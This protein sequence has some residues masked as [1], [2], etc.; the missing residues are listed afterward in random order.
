MK[1]P[2]GRHEKEKIRDLER[3]ADF[4]AMFGKQEFF[5][6]YV[7]YYKLYNKFPHRHWFK[8]INKQKLLGLLSE[9]FNLQDAA[10]FE[11]HIHSGKD[12]RSP[13]VSAYILG[14]ELLLCFPPWEFGN[15]N[16]VQVYY[17]DEVPEKKVDSIIQ[18]IKQC[19]SLK[20][21]EKSEVLL[22]MQNKDKNLEFYEMTM[23]SPIY[24]LAINYNADLLPLHELLLTRLNKK[25]DKGLIVFYGKSGTGKTSYIRYLSSRVGKQ[26]LFV[27]ANL[28][29][30]IG[31]AEFLNLLNDFHNSL[32]IIEDADSILKKRSND[33]DHVIVNLLNLADGV[34]SD[35]FHIQIICTFNN[36]IADI[37]PAL[38]RKGR[39]IAKYC[40]KELTAEKT[41]QLCRELG[42][43]FVPNH[44]M[45]LA[46]IYHLEERDFQISEKPKVTI[47]FKNN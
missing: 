7:Y 34:L 10:V 11:T 46:D 9:Q 45:T 5:N 20:K 33:P 2:S 35:F 28:T 14:E 8:D 6:P 16:D 23:H 13:G 27:P 39:L 25:D 38:L 15:A 40:F 22:L 24:E 41:N 21:V 47:G 12:V 19:F 26:K 4:S 32:L 18:V 36:D 44:E 31:S 42:Y 3:K 1:K 29:Y 37:D 43:Q 30:K 17:S